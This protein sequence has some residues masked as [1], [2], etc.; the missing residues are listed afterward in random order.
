MKEEKAQR[1]KG[2][3][4]QRHRGTKKLCVYLTVGLSF[5]IYSLLPV[6]AI[7]AESVDDTVNR[8]EK[9]YGEIH[10][11]QGAFTQTS[12][13]KDLERTEKYS[14]SF[15][16]KKPSMFRWKYA[17]PR[18]EEVIISGTEIWIYKASEKQAL[19]SK[20]N[21][22]AYS[23]LPIAMLESLEKMKAD[24][25]IK[26]A[27]ESVL[28]LVPK[29][30]MGFVKKIQ[31]EIASSEFPIKTLTIF[32]MYGNTIILKLKDVKINPGLDDSLFVFKI[33][34]GVEVHDFSQ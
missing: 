9:K 19:K 22:S 5:I 32:D 33:P 11:M 18:N 4:A 14:G 1:R 25:E 13:L 21:K 30:E 8:I 23:Q 24:Y 27:G 34:Q 15:S 12:Y 6:A 16:I 20:F 7:S 29:G 17:L 31:L 26:T 10:D 3:E 28:E 2:T